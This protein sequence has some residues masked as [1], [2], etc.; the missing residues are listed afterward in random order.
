ME[1]KGKE[2]VVRPLTLAQR[3]ELRKVGFDLIDIMRRANAQGAGADGE[4]ITGGMVDD[5]LA[6][7][8]PDRMN[9]LDAAGAAKQVEL[10]W[11]I[12][13]ASISGEGEPEKN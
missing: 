13:G 9:E 5:L 11:A 2:F 8:Y 6:C 10:F 1:I 4:K 7:V 3:R 12:L